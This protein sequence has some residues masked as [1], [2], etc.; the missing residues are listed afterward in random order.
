MRGNLRKPTPRVVCALAAAVAAAVGY[1]DTAG[2]FEIDVGDPDISARWD[3]T[4]RYNYARRVEG[5]DRHILAS[6]NYDDG[7]RNFDRG[8]VANRVDLLSEFDLKY[9]DSMGFRVSAAAWGDNAYRDL[10]NRNVATSNHL[11]NGAPALGLSGDT[12]RFHKGPS[13]EILDAFVFGGVDFDD[14]SFSIKVG[15]HT[16]Y[17]GEALLSPIHG[18]NYGQAPLDLRKLLSVPGT[19]AK[20]LLLPRNAVSAQLVMTP[21]LSFAA[22]YFLDWKQWRLPESG[23]Y[24]G[25]YDMLWDGGESLIV[26]PGRRLLRNNDVTPKK[27]G[28]GGLSARWSPAWLDGT[29]GAYYRRTA[30]IAPQVHVRPA[31]ATLPAATCGALGFSSLSAT[32][33][34]INPSAASIPQILGGNVGQYHLVYPGEVDI[35]GI[36]LSKSVAGVSVGAELS[37][38]KDMPLN[39]TPVTILPAT[40]AAL[41]PGAIAALPGEGKTGGAIGNTWH[42]IVNLMGTVA[43]TPLFDSAVW[44]AELQWNRW[45]KVTQGKVVFKGND[46][47]TGIDKVTKDFV[48]LS[49]NLTPTW[50]QIF[51]GVDLSA[52]M[53]YSIGLYGN[54][55]VAAGGNE[56]AGSYSLGIAADVYQK[57][58]FDLKYIDFVGPYRTDASGAI[59]SSNGLNPL[60]KDRG[61]VNFTFKTTF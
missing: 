35:M 17:W 5:Q 48:G 3:N 20:E 61:F 4:V 7:D 43:E 26:G 36:S 47:Y 46:A 8:T 40:L 6:P 44:L 9:R 49:F 60:L 34:Y 16:V 27:R 39:S 33:C 11:S 25:G 32:T 59:T 22:Q 58:R 21:E 55:A 42:G 57:Y 12:R 14:K 54:S 23:S 37:Y 38:R 52:P 10:D 30:D 15:K 53:S 18:V 50:F 19:E 31:V 45:D 51:P 28:D 13:G 41:T 24:L 1:P 56:D 2:A 29:L